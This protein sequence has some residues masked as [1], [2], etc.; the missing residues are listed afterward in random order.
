MIQDKIKEFLEDLINKLKNIADFS[1]YTL[2]NKIYTIMLML[3]LLAIFPLPYEFYN[4]LRTLICVGLGYYFYSSC[5]QTD[6]DVSFY[7]YAI[8]GLIILY[9]PLMPIHLTKPLW[10]LLNLGT[11]YF[12]FSYQKKIKQE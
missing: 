4:T 11:L 3:F 7:K 9:N 2:D 8:V 5:K 6:I 1:N 10:T 12:I